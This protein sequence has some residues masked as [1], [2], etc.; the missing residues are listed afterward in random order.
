[1]N[2]WNLLPF[3]YWL[4]I[5]TVT[6]HYLRNTYTLACSCN[7]LITWQLAAVPELSRYRSVAWGKMWS[8]CLW[9]W[10]DCWCQMWWVECF[11]HCW[12]PGILMHV[13]GV[14]H[15][16]HK[17]PVSDSCWIETTCWQEKSEENDQ[18][19]NGYSYSESGQE[20][21][22][23]RMC[24]TLRCI[25]TV[26]DVWTGPTPWREMDVVQSIAKT[27]QVELSQ[28]DVKSG[29]LLRQMGGSG[30]DINNGPNLPCVTNWGWWRW[31]NRRS[32]GFLI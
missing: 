19:K 16:V 1:M 32:D 17:H 7:K 10:H 28:K 29:F 3:L 26:E 30:Y 12:S 9:Q 14:F 15:E 11:S 25:I 21:I 6:E 8:H 2:G 20:S 4:L 18:I 5:H 31:C 27:G 23:E 22:S 24:W 13:S